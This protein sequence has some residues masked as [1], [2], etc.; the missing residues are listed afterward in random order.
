MLILRIA[1]DELG[2]GWSALLHDPAQRAIRSRID[3]AQAAEIVREVEALL[4]PPPVF[5]AGDEAARTRA[6]LTAG[7][8]LAAVWSA[9]GQVAAQAAERERARLSGEPTVLVVETEGAALSRLPWE[10]LAW[11]ADG[12]P[13]EDGGGA[14]VVRLV[15]GLAPPPVQPG[16]DLCVWSFCPT[17]EDPDCAAALCGLS[18]LLGDAVAPVAVPGRALPAPAA[19]KVELLSVVCHGRVVAGDGELRFGDSTRDSGE[20]GA[21]LAALLGRVAGVVLQVCSGGA[22]Q[23]G[24]L[25]TLAGRLLASGARFCVAPAGIIGVEA[26]NAFSGA[27]FGAL[28]GGGSLAAAISAGR[29]AIRALKQPYPDAR[30][31][32]VLVFVPDLGVM[33]GPPLV[34]SPEVPGWGHVGGELRGLLARA[35][36]LARGAG[37]CWVGVEH[38][39]AA[40]RPDEGGPRARS[41]ARVMPAPAHPVWSQLNEGMHVEQVGVLVPTPRMDAL[42]R[43]LPAGAG[44][45]ALWEALVEDAGCGVHLL[46]VADLRDLFTR[47]PAR[48]EGAPLERPRASALADGFEVLWGPEDGRALWP[49]AG[50]TIGRYV[51][52]AGVSC[53]LFQRGVAWDKAVSRQHLVYRGPGQLRAERPIRRM[54]PGA[55][56]AALR[57]ESGAIEVAA[58]EVVVLGNGTWLRGLARSAQVGVLGPLGGCLV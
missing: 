7:K 17:P 31:C 36:Q 20:V 47:D 29:G 48:T 40:L 58:G 26:S 32:R 42:A 45:D 41:L 55:S 44:L 19:R 12:L 43:A 39:I 28:R 8:R 38:L 46:T 54:R 56:L 24:T 35:T 18:A 9:V 53:P 21:L 15:D 10:L 57:T 16:E 25:R 27:F 6:E 5:V 22:P 11:S 30:P 1:E 49:Q 23:L 3:A 4:R 51:E 33:R 37:L 14:V 34:E 52:G 13:V 2:G 50:D